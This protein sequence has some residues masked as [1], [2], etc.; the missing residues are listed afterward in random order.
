M[1]KRNKIIVLTFVLLSALSCLIACGGKPKAVEQLQAPENLQINGTTLTWDAVEN[2]SGYTVNVDGNKTDTNDN[3]YDLSVLTEQKKYFI[4]IKSLGDEKK[5]KTSKWSQ[6]KEYTVGQSLEYEFTGLYNQSSQFFQFSQFKVVGIGNVTS[7]EIVVP[8]TYNGL[9]V[10]RIGQRAFENNVNL[11]KIILPN[12]IVG[13]EDLAFAGCT[14]LE[15][16]DL[17]SSL[18]Y[19]EKD[20]FSGSGIRTLDLTDTALR[21]FGC[22]DCPNLEAVKLPKNLSQLSFKC[23]ENT[24][25]LKSLTLPDSL[26]FIGGEAFVGSSI[27]SIKIPKKVYYIGESAFENTVINSVGFEE[28]SK[29]ETINKSAFKG[30]NNLKSIVI[31]AS[32]TTIGAYAFSGCANLT[33][34]T[35]EEGSK[36]EKI[37]E[38]AFKGCNNLKSIVIPASVT[39]IGAW[40][41]SGCTNLTS[42]TFEEGSKLET[43]D[44]SFLDSGITE[45]TIPK[46]VK[47]IESIAFMNL[48]SLKSVRFEDDSNVTVLPAQ[49]FDGCYNLTTIDFGK[50]SKIQTIEYLA[51]EKCVKLTAVDIPQSVTKIGDFAFRG[52]NAI[53]SITIPAGVESV[54]RLAFASWTEDQI[55]YVEGYSKAPDGWSSDWNAKC[56]A[57]IVWSKV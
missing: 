55:I 16:I 51:F 49:L 30:C 31:P 12:T 9:P 35:F 37:E 56:N 6:L 1:K 50:N 15:Y 48:S 2:A 57:T 5:Y 32:V 26:G 29:L 27:E 14:A 18:K 34:V 54:G 40:A 23:F 33:S 10:I 8:S 3:K 44:R 45:F 39:T 52:C 36:L 42:V 7:D 13:I 46:N 22:V 25:K 21:T 20:V 28:G 4:Q 53:K 17:P 43:L 41:F 11:K 38:W 24:P 19:M 47:K